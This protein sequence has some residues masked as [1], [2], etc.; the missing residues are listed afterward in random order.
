M[1]DNTERRKLPDGWRWV[2][3]GDVCEFTSGL[4]KGTKPPF[5]VV[6]ILRNTNFTKLGTLD[7]SDVAQEEVGS[8]GA[9]D[10]RNGHLSA[11][12]AHTT[13]LVGGDPPKAHD[14]LPKIKGQLHP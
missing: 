2:K 13:F 14:H 10:L 8:F 12:E 4:W 9:D 1:E 11:P 3:L 6:R 7:L 5:Q